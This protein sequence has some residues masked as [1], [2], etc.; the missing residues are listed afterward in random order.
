TVVDVAGN[1]SPAVIGT[2][3]KDARVPVVTNVAITDGDYAEGDVISLSVTLDEDVTVSEAVSTLAIEVGETTRQAS[4]VSE[5]TGVLLYQYTVLAGDN[6][7]GAGVIAVANGISLNG[8]FI[9]D[10][11]GNDASL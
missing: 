7:D 5:N 9:R 11:G 8:D 4:F 10:A 2:I 3:N 1:T 6:T